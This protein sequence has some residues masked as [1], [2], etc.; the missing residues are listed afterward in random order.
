MHIVCMLRST[1][2]GQQMLIVYKCEDVLNCEECH[3]S[4]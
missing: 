3:H 4:V 1:L 2:F